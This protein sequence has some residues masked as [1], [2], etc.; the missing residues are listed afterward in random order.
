MD[1]QSL[2][3]DAVIVRV[4]PCSWFELLMGYYHQ[5]L[6]CRSTQLRMLIVR[7]FRQ[8]TPVLQDRS[9]GMK[10]ACEP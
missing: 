3:V 2:P 10:I 8:L 1:G 7:P 4:H 5:T 9:P 6:A